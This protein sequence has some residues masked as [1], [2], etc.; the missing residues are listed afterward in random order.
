MGN[1]IFES[2]KM[3]RAY[4][5]M[6]LPLVFSMIV[7]LVYNLVD[8]YFVAQTGDTNIVAGV[9]LC[10]PVFTT[11]MAFGNIFG[12]GGSSI[13]SRLLGSGDGK[14]VRHISSFCFYVTL[15]MG[16]LVAVVMLVFQTPI[17]HLLGADQ[18][19]FAPARDYY[20]YIAIGA[21][22]VMLTYI[23][24]NLLRSEGLSRES[25][26]GTIGGA[27]V[28][29]ILDPILI[30][31]LSMGAAG[32]AIA[33]VI[34]Y[35][36]GDLFHGAMV[37]TRSRNLSLSVKEI[38]IPRDHLVQIFGIGIPAAIV[39]VMQSLSMVL[40][41]QFLG[42]FG[43]DKIAAMGIAQKVSL[44]VLLILTG[45]SFGGQPLFGYYFG[46]K[47]NKRLLELIRFCL[48][49]IVAVA[50]V[51]SAVLI[52]LAPT[53]IQA[54]MDDAG[55]V[56]DG[57]SM[58]RWQLVSMPFVGIVLVLTIVFQ[59][60]GKILGSF[61]LSISR[62]GVIFL[63]VLMIAYSSV[64]YTGII[65]SQAVADLLTAIFAAGL[66]MVQIYRDLKPSP[67]IE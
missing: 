50:V 33:T 24:S 63:A 61:L 18:D 25:M 11:L 60:F 45:F 16:V 36:C 41:N 64:G 47:D 53:V 58:L 52:I 22:I 40:I 35:L 44:I 42:P 13:I 23:H 31:G 29:M 19:T 56:S 4:L 6:S 30:S 8:T 57:T 46:K 1:E 20:I 43:N 9:S 34:G 48:I 39:N 21:P 28:N 3:S 37:L 51:L 49:F 15:G 7:S 2:Q 62:Q 14:G 38:G 27:V 59:A 26:I 65:A 54:F 12:Q 17:L 55:I 66:F 67:K 5:R 10:A 32:A